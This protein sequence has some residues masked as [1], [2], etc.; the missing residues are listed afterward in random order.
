M[1]QNFHTLE[2]QPV[3]EVV[4]DDVILPVTESSVMSRTKQR[5][6]E[7]S[8]AQR[9]DFWLAVTSTL[10]GVA[11][12]TAA[13]AIEKHSPMSKLPTVFRGAGYALDYVDGYF[14]KRSATAVDDGATTE[15]GA[16]ADPLADKLNN[17]L[18]EIALV[19]KGRLALGD[20]AVRAARDASVTAARRYVT[21]KTQGRV[22][23]K[24]NKFGKLN[25]L[26]RDGV[27]LFAS[28]KFAGEHPTLNRSL[29]TIADVYSV[30]SGA[31]TAKQLVDAYQQDELDRSAADS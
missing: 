19:Q 26:V 13:F 9:R 2:T 29:Q 10:G 21:K 5:Y 23:V 14:A 17:T 8:S 6:G 18:N 24:A 20:L 16:I 28:T 22:D 31:Y 15:L 11:L 7:M 27:N 25:T 1:S 12:T 3:I 4:S 30:A